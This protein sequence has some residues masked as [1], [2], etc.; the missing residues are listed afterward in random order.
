VPEVVG[1]ISAFKLNENVAA[2]F[3]VARP[4]GKTF[5]L[6][7]NVPTGP[8]SGEQYKIVAVADDMTHDVFPIVTKLLLKIFASN[9]DPVN[10]MDNGLVVS[11]VL[12]MGVKSFDHWKLQLAKHF[13]GIPLIFIENLNSL[14]LRKELMLM[15]FMYL[16]ATMRCS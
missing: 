4:F 15:T 7:L 11:I 8:W 10:L 9:P 5:N 14:I 3:I 2:E 12:T 16:W 1:M 6:K 13:D